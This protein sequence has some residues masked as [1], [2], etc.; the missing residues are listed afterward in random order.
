MLKGIVKFKSGT[1]YGFLAVDNQEDVFFHGRDLRDTKF[2][3]LKVGDE[4]LF[5]RIDDTKRGTTAREVK[6]A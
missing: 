1:G 6:L 2:D 4:V 3:D 5:D